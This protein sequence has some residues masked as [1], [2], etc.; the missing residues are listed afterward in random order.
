MR[1]AEEEMRALEMEQR[2]EAIRGSADDLVRSLAEQIESLK[3]DLP[4]PAAQR[5]DVEREIQR[6]QAALDALR[7]T[8]AAKPRSVQGLRPQP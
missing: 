4:E 5:A 2:V 6:L 1:K 3:Q 7:S 8:G